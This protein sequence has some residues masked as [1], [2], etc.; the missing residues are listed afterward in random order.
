MI[1]TAFGFT[2]TEAVIIGLALF[3]SSTIIIAKVLSDK[4]ELTRLNGQIAIG[5][6][7]IDDIIATFALLFVAAQTGTNGSL[8]SLDVVTL[9]LKGL[10][11]VGILALFGIKLL[12]RLM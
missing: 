8:T 2:R 1:G 11:F 3:F 5:V 12:P 6:I 7:L 4:R 9:I 10:V